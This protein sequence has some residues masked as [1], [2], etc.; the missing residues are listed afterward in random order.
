MIPRYLFPEGAAGGA[1]RNVHTT[2][3]G[4]PPFL[5]FAVIFYSPAVVK[6]SILLVLFFAYWIDGNDGKSALHL[7]VEHFGWQESEN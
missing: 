5:R 6:F 7:M 1:P 3:A 2:S 4:A